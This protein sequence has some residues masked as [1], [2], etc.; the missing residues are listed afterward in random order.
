MLDDC[1]CECGIVGCR[2]LEGKPALVGSGTMNASLEDEEDDA[3]AELELGPWYAV[4][5]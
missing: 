5:K 1:F 4:G 3:A 2:M